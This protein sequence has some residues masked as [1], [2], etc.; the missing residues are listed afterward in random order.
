[1]DNFFAGI[2]HFIQD[3][4]N[5]YA[6]H[7]TTYLQLCIVAILFAIAI[8]VPLGIIAAQNAQV[9]F[10]TANLSGL[11]RA[12][13]TIAFFALALVILRLGIGF[14]PAVI[15]LVILG[16]PPILLNTIA[17]LQGLDAAVIDAARGMGMTRLQVLLR[18]QLP[19]VLPVIAAGTRTTAVQIVATAPLAAI[20]G[21]GGYGEYIIAGIGLGP[22]G[23][24]ELF[25]G[26]IPVVALALIAEFG[27]AA[28]QR[29]I[30]PR[31]LKDNALSSA[32]NMSPREGVVSGSEGL[33][34]LP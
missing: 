7:T 18:V 10:W 28:I 3:P 32:S 24:S 2:W 5:D 17:G 27:L 13:P 22:Q 8:A 14:T 4:K 21:A 16:I 33:P 15:S 26:G 34:A 20:I 9:A 1:M 29:A 12:I 31:A 11:F 19:L 25:A 30:T 23:T 6:G